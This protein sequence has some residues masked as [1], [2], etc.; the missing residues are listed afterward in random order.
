MAKIQ[1]IVGSVD[2]AADFSATTLSC[3]LQEKGHYVSTQEKPV[4]KHLL[5]IEQELLLIITS[6]TGQ[7]ELPANLRPLWRKLYTKKPAL[8]NIC[9]ATAVLGDASYEDDFCL[10]GIKLD[11]LLEELGGKKIQPALLIDAEKT[12][13]PEIQITH[14]GEMLIQQKKQL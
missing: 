12:N 8:N 14:W 3:A 11:A 9:F 4:L 5:K 1:L 10:G 7:G 6:T 13:N 2:G